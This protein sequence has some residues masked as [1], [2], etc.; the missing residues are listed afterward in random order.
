M[1]E[2]VK[3]FSKK[4]DTEKTLTA[5]GKQTKSMNAPKIGYVDPQIMAIDR[6]VADLSGRHKKAIYRR[7]LWLQPDRIAALQLRMDRHEYTALA[8]DAVKYIGDRLGV[9]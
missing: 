8:N 3:V 4:A 1:V 2:Q 6:I 5:R 7:Y 9:L